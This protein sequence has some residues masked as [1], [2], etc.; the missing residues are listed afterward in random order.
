M[1]NT[2]PR[3]ALFV[4]AAMSYRLPQDH[5]AAFLDECRRGLFSQADSTGLGELSF[6]TR[7]ILVVDEW[8]GVY[9]L[10]RLASRVDVLSFSGRR[11]GFGTARSTAIAEARLAGA[12]RA[13]LVDADGQHDPVEVARLARLFAVSEKA[14]FIPHRRA[15]DLPL[16]DGGDLDRGLAERFEAYIVARACHRDDLQQADMQP[17]LF[18]FDRRALDLLAA[19]MESRAYSWD[20]EATGRLVGSDL[21]LGFPEVDTRPQSVTFFSTTDSQAN[22]RFLADRFGEASVR[23]GWQS[24]V[25]QPWVRQR[26]PDEALGRHARHLDEALSS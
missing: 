7:T 8:E 9:D 12:D 10:A 17:G 6:E 2:A 19:S 16:C 11:R 18:M 1:D 21:P 4:L 20:L 23:A 3:P 22:L 26:S 14:A 25:A 15:V 24:F 5:V 13:L